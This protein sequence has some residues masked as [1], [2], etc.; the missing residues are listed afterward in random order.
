M[1]V[2]IFL[3]ERANMDGKLVLALSGPSFRKGA[4]VNEYTRSLREFKKVY[5]AATQSLIGAESEVYIIK[6]DEGSLITA[7][8]P[9]LVDTAQHVLN[10]LPEI[11][12]E[13][14]MEIWHQL[15]I[16]EIPKVDA[17]TLSVIEALREAYGVAKNL[18]KLFSILRKKDDKLEITKDGKPILSGDSYTAAKIRLPQFPSEYDDGVM[19]HVNLAIKQPDLTGDDKWRFIHNGKIIVASVADS[20]YRSKVAN[21]EESFSAGDIIECDLEVKRVH[22][23]QKTQVKYSIIKVHRTYRPSPNDQPKLT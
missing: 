17:D 16:G 19:H 22:E 15:S 13:K 7:L 5:S 11:S 23:R 8:I 4:E 21:R 14:L 12:P 2:Y 20:Q 3:I 10:L 18:R 6:A 1:W 9:V